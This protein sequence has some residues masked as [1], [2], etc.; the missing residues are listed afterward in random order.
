VFVTRAAYPRRY[1][2]S[3]DGEEAIE[4]IE[5]AEPA[6]WVRLLVGSGMI[7]S[8]LAVLLNGVAL[9]FSLKLHESPNFGIPG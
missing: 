9:A 6:I 4:S 5:G 7:V 3:A 2:F 1:T 8:V